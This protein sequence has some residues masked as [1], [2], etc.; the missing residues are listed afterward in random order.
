MAKYLEKVKGFLKNF[1]HFKV[2]RISQAKNDRIDALAKLASMKTS[3][4]NWSVTK[5]I[6][7]APL[8]EKNKS[9]CIHGK[10]DLNESY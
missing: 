10:G 5:L 9:M 7:L 2:E 3:N 8:I 4:G 6:V 1:E